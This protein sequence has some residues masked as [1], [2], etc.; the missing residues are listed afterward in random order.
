VELLH[1]VNIVG[2]NLKILACRMYRKL[3][4]IWGIIAADRNLGFLKTPY[5]SVQL[6]LFADFAESQTED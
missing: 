2:R 1:D 3:Q 6:I 5:F 4:R